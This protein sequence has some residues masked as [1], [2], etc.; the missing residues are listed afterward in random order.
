MFFVSMVAR[1]FE[2][3]VKAD[4]MMVLEAAQGARKSSAC[5][6]IGGKWFSDSMPD[7]TDGKDVSQHLPRK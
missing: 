6:I 4:Y 3:G 5:A 1:V 2:P 7:V